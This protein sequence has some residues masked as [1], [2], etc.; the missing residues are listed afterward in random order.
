[1]ICKECGKQHETENIYFCPKCEVKH[2]KRDIFREMMYKLDNINNLDRLD[3]SFMN[4]FSYAEME[5]FSLI[6]KKLI[7]KYHFPDKEEEFVNY[8]SKEKL[9]EIEKTFFF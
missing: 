9:Q 1:M 2:Q 8:Y 4:G 7:K 3:G 6:M 5:R